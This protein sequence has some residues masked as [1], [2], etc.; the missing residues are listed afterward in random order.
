MLRQRSHKSMRQ[1]QKSSHQMFDP[2]F[3]PGACT[4]MVVEQTQGYKISFDLTKPNQSNQGPIPWSR[5]W[6]L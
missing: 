2:L 4:M 1:Q 3:A 5:F 6:W